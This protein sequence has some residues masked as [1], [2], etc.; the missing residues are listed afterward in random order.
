MQGAVTFNNAVLRFLSLGL[1]CSG[2]SGLVS[3]R[4]SGIQ[5]PGFRLEGFRAI[6]LWGLAMLGVERLS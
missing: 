6:G 1:S 5:A 4:G 2:L 3:V